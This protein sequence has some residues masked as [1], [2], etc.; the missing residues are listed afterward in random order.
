MEQKKDTVR[1]TFAFS[2]TQTYTLSHKVQINACPELNPGFS[3]S[4][5]SKWGQGHHICLL[6][7][8]LM[9]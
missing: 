5:E 8:W 3:D 1:L 2:N 4:T 7:L 6:F 9:N